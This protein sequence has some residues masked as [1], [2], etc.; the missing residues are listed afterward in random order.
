MP[1]SI[2]PRSVINAPRSHHLDRR[3]NRLADDTTGEDDDLL[4][5]VEVAEMLSVSPQWLSIGRVRT[6][7]PPF[8]RLS[9]RTVRYRRGAIKQWLRERVHQRTAEYQTGPRLGR[10]PGSKLVNGR[11]IAPETDQKGK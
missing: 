7:G 11:V 6:Y 8:I 2:S 1:T 9:R 10:Q 5:T 4:S 3:A